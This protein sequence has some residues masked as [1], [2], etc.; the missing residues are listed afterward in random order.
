MATNYETVTSLLKATCNAIRDK[1]GSAELI[2]HQDIPSRIQNL[3]TSKQDV[4]SLAS[5][6]TKYTEA[7]EVDGEQRT[8][9]L[10]Q[11][12]D[13]S[14]ETTVSWDSVT[15]YFSHSIQNIEGSE[16]GAAAVIT[17]TSTSASSYDNTFWF[18]TTVDSSTSEA[19]SYL[20]AVRAKASKNITSNLPVYICYCHPTGSTS[21][22]SM[23]FSFPVT[24]EWQ[25]FYAIVNIPAN[26]YM[27]DNTLAFYR[28]GDGVK[29]YIDWVAAYDITGSSFANMT[30]GAKATAINSQVLSGKSYYK[31]GMLYTGT[32][33]NKG[34]VTSSITSQNG[35]YTIPAGYHNGEGVITA[36]INS[37]TLST[38]TIG[39][40]S[41]GYITASSGVSASGYLSTSNTASNSINPKNLDSD[42]ESSNIKKGV[43]IF[44]VTGTYEGGTG[45]AGG[46]LQNTRSDTRKI[47]FSGLE[48]TD[49]IGWAVVCWDDVESGTSSYDN[50]VSLIYS[51][52]SSSV[53]N[54]SA[55]D[56]DGVV[57]SRVSNDTFSHTI[58]GNSITIN[59]SSSN[60]Y[61]FLGSTNYRFFP[62]YASGGFSVDAW[63]V[64]ANFQDFVQDYPFEYTD[65]IVVGDHACLG[66]LQNTNQ[67]VNYSYSLIRFLMTCS[68]TSKNMY[69]KV[70]YTQDTESSWDYAIIGQPKVALTASYEVDNSYTGTTKNQTSG[71]ILVNLGTGGSGWFDIKFIK[72]SSNSNGS[73][74]FKFYVEYWAE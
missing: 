13:F 35:T 34:A 26:Y 5:G 25:I 63:T 68:N 31:D 54:Y 48:N 24:T 21:R 12:S 39:I 36:K 42:L 58:S 41:S 43:T 18:N 52:G 72:D 32:M 40:N 44:G 23:S 55:I 2:N 60:S 47:T 64:S 66:E 17:A 28:T 16:N 53:Y 56:N 29:Y 11:P 61:R 1:E 10:V 50:I 69:A 62:F 74:T 19:K 71:S 65:T 49:M 38:P 9:V 7:F 3:K 46:Y 30:F 15:S 4:L 73:D 8:N 14:D 33:V 70:W 20:I 59:A 22:T 51:P 27:Y 57:F 6:L 45:Y 67:G 37:G